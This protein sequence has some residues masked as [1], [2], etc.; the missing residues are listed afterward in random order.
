MFQVLATSRFQKELRKLTRKYPAFHT[1]ILNAISLL[2][3]APEQGDHLGNGVY[4][5]RIPISG[6]PAG[7]SYGARVIHA[8]ISIKSRVHL[9]SVYDKSDKKDLLHSELKGIF[10]VVKEIRNET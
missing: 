6:K 5:M 8:V 3:V 4:K 2:S 7:K 1:D 9:L 10:R